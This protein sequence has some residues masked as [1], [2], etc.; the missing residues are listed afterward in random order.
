[1]SHDRHSSDQDEPKGPRP[2]ALSVT[3]PQQIMA[4]VLSGAVIG[5]LLLIT[6][7]VFNA[8]PPVVPWSVPIVLVVIAIPALW[9]AKRLGGR[10]EQ[11][12]V[13]PDEGVR[14][15]VMGKSMLMTGAVLA[16]GHLVYVLKWIAQLDIPGPRDRVIHGAVTLVISV[17][18]AVVGGALERACI[19][20]SGDGEG[21]NTGQPA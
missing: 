1:M 19:V 14:A 5:Y 10:L 13:P 2:G 17:V 7:D 8:V 18:F 15:L 21:T 12:M 4:S 9:Y 20:D 16:G 6:F 11:R 3:T